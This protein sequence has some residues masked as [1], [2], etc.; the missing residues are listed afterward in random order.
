MKKVVW[1]GAA[2]FR[3]LSSADLQQAGVEAGVFSK[4]SFA[5]RQPVEVEDSVAEALIENPRLFGKFGIH[6]DVAEDTQPAEAALE[7]GKAS[8]TGANQESTG[9]P[10][11]GAAKAAGSSTRTR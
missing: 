5:R 10:S 4:T 8:E 7:A 9:T 1:L 2:H 3:E 6:E 11:A